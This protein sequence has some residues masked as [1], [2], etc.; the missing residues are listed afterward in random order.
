MPATIEWH[1]KQPVL[2]VTYSGTLTIRDYETMRKQ[3]DAALA[4]RSDDDVIVIVDTQA[5][6]GFPEA[7]KAEHASTVLSYAN[8]HHLFI[9]VSNALYGKIQ[10]S[11]TPELESHHPVYFFDSREAALEA[12]RTLGR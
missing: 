9:I 5:L 11:M 7:G 8:V 2:L 10:R 3:R 12:A 6:D 4:E 1:P